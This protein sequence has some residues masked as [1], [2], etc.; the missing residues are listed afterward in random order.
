MAK[1]AFTCS[2]GETFPSP[3][4][5]GMIFPKPLGKLWSCALAPKVRGPMTAPHGTICAITRG[6]CACVGRVVPHKRSVWQDIFGIPSTLGLG[7]GEDGLLIDLTFR[8]GGKYEKS[9]V[10]KKLKS[11]S[12]SPFFLSLLVYLLKAKFLQYND[13]RTKFPTFVY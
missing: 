12:T 9:T 6:K 8:V 13:R 5:L 3:L 2:L 1:K 4:N 11:L 10:S 7:G